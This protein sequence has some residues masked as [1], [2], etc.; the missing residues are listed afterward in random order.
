MQ[1]VCACI[2]MHT[3][4]ALSLICMILLFTKKTHVAELPQSG[5]KADLVARLCL[6]D[7]YNTLGETALRA[8]CRKEGKRYFVAVDLFLYVRLFVCLFVYYRAF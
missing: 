1:R 7:K 4:S 6:F 3:H 8:K 5:N 2:L